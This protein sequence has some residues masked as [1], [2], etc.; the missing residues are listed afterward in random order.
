MQFI[1]ETALI[2]SAELF[3]ISANLSQLIKLVRTRDRKGL[4]AINQTLNAAGNI[5]WATYFFSRQLF[6]PFTTNLT[7]LVITAIV[8]GFTLGNK[9]QL[10]RGIAAIAIIGPLTGSLIIYYPGISGWI[11]VVYNF[12]AILPWIVRIIKTKQTSGISA[13]SL[14]LAIGAILCTLMYGILT[15]SIPLIVGT[16]IGLGLNLIV[17]RYYYTYRIG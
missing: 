14:Y 6:V 7:M 13:R 10:V 16:L 4:S 12:I 8:L 15:N 2:I 1:I 3:F 17:L 5:A 11:G 9:T